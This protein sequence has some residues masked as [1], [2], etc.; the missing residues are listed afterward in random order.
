M[1]KNT[2]FAPFKWLEE[3]NNDNLIIQTP[4][5]SQSNDQIDCLACSECIKL[6]ETILINCRMNETV[7]QNCLWSLGISWKIQTITFSIS[8]ACIA[9]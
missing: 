9:D 1:N 4:S 6:V 5:T 8:P 7:L 3:E 2:I